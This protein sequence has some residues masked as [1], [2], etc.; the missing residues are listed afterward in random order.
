MWGQAVSWYKQ[1]IVC[2]EASLSQ[3]RRGT[4]SY[5]LIK[6]I[7][8]LFFHVGVAITLTKNRAAPNSTKFSYKNL[9]TAGPLLPAAI[10]HS[11]IP[12]NSMGQC[13]SRMCTVAMSWLENCQGKD[14][15]RVVWHWLIPVL[16]PSWI[17][18]RRW[19]WP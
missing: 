7:M 4:L 18:S 3:D 9:P 2:P 12:I 5:P 19:S 16:E 8:Y 10:S 15:W 11:R 13:C 6:S 17:C 14:F 1:T